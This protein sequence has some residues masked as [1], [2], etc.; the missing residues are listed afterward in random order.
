MEYRED[1][2]IIEGVWKNGMIM[3]ETECVLVQQKGDLNYKGQ[4][5]HGKYDGYGVLKH[6]DGT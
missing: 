2:T 4:L 1:S 6:L 5:S 3:P